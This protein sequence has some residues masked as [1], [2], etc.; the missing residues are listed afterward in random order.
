MNIFD[1]RVEHTILFM[2]SLPKSMYNL[3]LQ[4]CPATLLQYLGSL[5]EYYLPRNTSEEKI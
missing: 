5:R 4:L 3:P 1:E 2:L